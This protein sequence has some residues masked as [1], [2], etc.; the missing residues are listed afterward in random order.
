VVLSAHSHQFTNQYLPNAGGKPTLVTQ[1]YSYS[2]A[3]ADVTL[4]LDPEMKDIVNK[5]ATIV[6]AYADQGAGRNTDE[7]SQEL[8]DAVNSTVAPL[9]SE[10]IATTDIP[11]TRNLD[12]NGE[13]L[14]YDIVTDAFRWYMKTDISILNIGSLRA[15][16]DAGEITTGDAYSVLPFHDQIYALRMTGQQ[17]KDLLNQQWTRTVKPDHLLQISGFS[18]SYDESRDP[19]D[20]VTSITFNGEEM[21]MNA[22]Y[23]V[24]TEDFLAHGGDGYT[25]MNEGVLVA[26]GALDVDEFIAY[27]KYIPSPIHEQT[28]G[29]INPVKSGVE[30]E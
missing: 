30:Q 26:Y 15:D 17:I 1:A 18:Y 13:S 27:L 8:L 5:T 6:T 3:Y 10:V 14:L 25:V 9:I 29:R 21:D 23:T 7:N 28:G 12:E 22:Y 20:R 16:I 4:E 2:S 19:S 11:L 24:A